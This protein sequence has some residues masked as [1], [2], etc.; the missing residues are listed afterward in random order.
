VKKQPS[1]ALDSQTKE[2]A[3]EAVVMAKR[4]GK[5][6]DYSEASL[7]VVEALLAEASEA[8]E[9]ISEDVQEALVQQLGCYL[10]AVGHRAYGG[11]TLWFEERQQPILVVG[12]PDARIAIATWDKVRSRLQG[13]EADNMPFFWAGFASR[14][15]KPKHGSDVLIC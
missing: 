10:L 11:R 8:I 9:T 4:L 3:A 15:R 2:L 7:E 1:Q 6:L 14:A 12:E 5:T 13:D